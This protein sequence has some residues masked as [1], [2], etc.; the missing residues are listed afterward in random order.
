MLLWVSVTLE[1]IQVGEVVVSGVQVRE[2]VHKRVQW[3]LE[4]QLV[5][6]GDG[7]DVL[8]CSLLEKLGGVT[9]GWILVM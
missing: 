2:L 4:V 3:V 9:A 8:C 6:T 5:K 7:L 1:V